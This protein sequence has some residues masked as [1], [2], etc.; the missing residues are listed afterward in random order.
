MHVRLIN[1]WKIRPWR[2]MC[3]PWLP[4][5]ASF[6][7]GGTQHGKEG[8]KKGDSSCDDWLWCRWMAEGNKN[9]RIRNSLTLWSQHCNTKR[10][11]C[12]FKYKQVAI[13]KK[14]VIID[15]HYS[16]FTLFNMLFNNVEKHTW[17]WCS[18]SVCLTFSVV[19]CFLIEA[20]FKTL[21]NVCIN[22][23]SNA[24]LYG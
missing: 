24:C 13:I 11:I 5:A 16:F 21:C 10:D 7:M 8:L 4:F 3:R 12:C 23:S 1:K 2:C 20:N 22:T 15:F 19:L 17:Y 18:W 9:K 6:Q 14:I